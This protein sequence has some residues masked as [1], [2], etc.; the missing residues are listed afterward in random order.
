LLAG[1]LGQISSLLPKRL[2]FYVA[3]PSLARLNSLYPAWKFQLPPSSNWI[4]KIFGT[5]S[6]FA[7]SKQLSGIIV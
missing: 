7:A 2:L 5:R 1:V 3:H 4:M 6:R